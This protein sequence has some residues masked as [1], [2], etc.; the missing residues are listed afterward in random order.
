MLARVAQSLRS[1]WRGPYNLK[2]IQ[3]SV[4][5][6][7]GPSVSGVPVNEHAAFTC[8]AF[9]D[10]VNQISSDVAKLPLNLKKRRQEGGSDDFTASKTYKIL[11]Y[12]PNPEMRSMVFRRTLTAHALVYGNGYAEIQRESGTGQPVALWPIHPNRVQPY[13]D[14]AQIDDG[15]RFPLRYKVDA[16]VELAPR[17]VIHIQGLGCDGVM[18]YN[19][20]DYARQALGLALASERFASAFF[21]NQTR[22]GGILV[23]DQP[24]DDEQAEELRA[25][26]NAI[27]QSADKAFKLLLLD[28]GFTYTETG[29]KPNDA[30]MTEIRNQQIEEVARFLN[31]PPHKLKHLDRS[32]NNNIEH[33]GLEYYTGCLLNW[34][35]AWEEELNAKLISPL[36]Q[37]QQFIKHNVKAFLRGDTAAQTA[38]YTALLDRGVICADD[39]LEF[40]DMNPQSGGQGKMYLVQGAMVPK[41]KIAALADAT[42]TK[43]TMKP[44]PA[45]QPAPTP[46]AGQRELQSQLEAAE[47]TRDDAL[48]KAETERDLRVALE[49]TG[50]ATA[51][52]LAE[53][54]DAETQALSLAAQSTAIVDELRQQLERSDTIA[55]EA[56][57]AK[58][59]EEAAR[60]AAEARSAES[61]TLAAEALAARALAEQAAAAANQEADAARAKAE[62]AVLAVGEALAKA[63]RAGLDKAASDELRL[64]AENRATSA[65]AAANAA[66][67]ESVRLQGE[68]AEAAI[69]EQQA[70]DDAAA[71]KVLA[72]QASA[73]AQAERDAHTAVVLGAHEAAEKAELERA[74][75]AAEAE[76][77]FKASDD[78]RLLAESAETARLAAQ[79]QAES[80]A[81]ARAGAERM[82]AEVGAELER[83]RAELADAQKLEREAQVSLTE[84]TTHITERDQSIAALQ[85]DL[86]AQRAANDSTS[87]EHLSTL[88]TLGRLSTER[89]TELAERDELRAL[90]AVET[91]ARGRFETAIRELEQ[92]EAD[93]H[94]AQIAAHRALMVDVMRRM[95]ER[96]TDRA[97]RA[98]ATPEKLRHW[99]ETFYDGHEDLCRTAL[100]PAVRIHCAF[101]QSVE[102]PIDATRRLV[103]AHVDESKRQ[104]LTV[105]DGDADE[106][107]ASLPA[108]LHRWET[109]RVAVI[110]DKLLHKELEFARKR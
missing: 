34:I 69:R 29:T 60:M 97:R 88:E 55:R 52:Q 92:A 110:A 35:T 18:G 47:A 22:F 80:E 41:D 7:Y 45:P 17:D 19:L 99:L 82:A 42:I 70:R 78:A 83:M 11:K 20:V 77:A 86:E 14:K 53:K 24:M 8:S 96:E 89:A 57:V 62:D 72:V 73:T 67:A 81:L 15:R 48:A 49:A 98:Q 38:L 30:Q 27:H 54:R 87:A 31:M 32:T 91:E 65:L 33:Q 21:G 75:L 26:I 59:V 106:I 104:I 103:A 85:A 102:D 79:A 56:S 71:A 23:S 12:S 1:F 2:S 4:F 50:Q 90:V 105:L 101:V 39:V 25:R 46:G 10:G 58:T 3:D 76:L 107:A 28:K 51:A 9:W 13:Y 43:N 66:T 74:R 16:K 95:V 6:D 36:E 94:G 64:A 61:A 68:L 44:E 100:L 108:L 84:W 37:S 109:E 5:S 93:R 40:E 63:D